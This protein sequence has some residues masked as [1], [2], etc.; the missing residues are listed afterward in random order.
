METPDAQPGEQPAVVDAPGGEQPQDR[1]N[2]QAQLDGLDGQGLASLLDHLN[3]APAPA[4]PEAPAPV[5]TDVPAGEQPQE[6]VVEAPAA[7]APA[8]EEPRST[9]KPPNRLSVRSLPVDQQ[10][11]LATALDLVRH[12]KATDIHD[13]IRQAAGVTTEAPAA[14][15][16]TESPA[17]TEAPAAPAAPTKP[18]AVAEVENRIKDL[19]AQRRQAHAEFNT[20]LAQDLTEQIEDAQVDLVRAENAARVSQTQAQSYQQDYDSAV[21]E[22]EAKYPDSL[23]ED[24]TFYRVLDDRVTAAQARKDPRLSDPRYILAMADEVAADL[25]VTGQKKETTPPPAAPARP[26]R[27]AGTTVAPGHGGA[28]RPSADQLRA[29]IAETP[30]EDLLAVMDGRR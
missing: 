12:G 18:S 20:D 30:V 8:Q 22:M 13:A 28:A 3:S 2:L 6:V 23:D 14:T 4:S 16:T 25:K 10:V 26:A 5:A 7:E 9:A 15:A 1:V 24:S 19:R 29:L 11:Q 17:T 27:P 21:D